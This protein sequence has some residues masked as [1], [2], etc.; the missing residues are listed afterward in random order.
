MQ[1]SRIGTDLAGYRIE[2][3]VGR[4]GMSVVYLAEQVRLKR[5]AALKLL[6]PELADDA[7]FRER[8][9]RESELAASLDHPNVI[10]IF[11]AGETDGILYIAMRYVE[12]QDL[13]QLIQ[14]EGK[15]APEQALR[16]LQPVAEALDYAHTHGLVHRDVKPGNILL[17]DDGPVYLS[18]F[19]L[20]R[21]VDEG[22]S[23]TEAGELVGSIDYVAP[24]QIEGGPVDGRADVYSLGCVTYQ[25]LTGSVPFPRDSPMAK[26]WAHLRDTPLPAA[27]ITPDLPQ[28]LDPVLQ[29]GL[30]KKPGDRYQ[31]ATGLTG[32]LQA[33][34]APATSTTTRKRNRRTILAGT[35]A[36]LAAIAALTVAL[37]L[38]L[39][40][41]STTPDPIF[42]L[43]G[44]SESVVRIDAATGQP[45]AALPFHLI[46]AIAAG[47]GSVWAVEFT[48]GGP[49]NPE[50]DLT[51][52]EI[53]PEDDRRGR[54]V[55]LPRSAVCCWLAAGEG[56]VWLMVESTSAPGAAMLAKVDPDTGNI[57][58]MRQRRAARRS[59][60]LRQ[61]ATELWATELCGFPT[62][63]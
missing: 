21:R 38:A 23:L 61:L 16:I 63:S 56:A 53:D 12:G 3:L 9:L 26:L 25:C 45:T 22:A 34:L 8:F 32:G 29:R 10:P 24:E 15:L 31:T 49:D 17:A 41:G 57:T 58:R 30:A 39:G 14:Q 33:A 18:D 62:P 40:R 44:D 27:A 28:E 2:R 35:L 59:L 37:V 19:G 20:T 42:P 46:F 50:G 7:R 13:R 36:A 52:V 5:R 1:D 48:A 60:T 54:S 47:L 51:L 11:D 55:P 43:A 4:G 6:A